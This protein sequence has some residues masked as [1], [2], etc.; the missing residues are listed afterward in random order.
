MENPPRLQGADDPLFQ[1]VARGEVLPQSGLQLGVQIV[2][3]L[4][5]HG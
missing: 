4:D 2:V 1:E 3:V 5:A